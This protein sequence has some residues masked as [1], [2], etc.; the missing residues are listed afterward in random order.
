[1]WFITKMTY[2]MAKHLSLIGTIVLVGFGYCYFGP[3]T[4]MEM[5]LVSIQLDVAGTEQQLEDPGLSNAQKVNIIKSN[6][7]KAEIAAT[8]ET[9]L[10]IY[11]IITGVFALGGLILTKLGFWRLYSAKD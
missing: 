2:D 9:N 10:L 7:T 1:M 5:D 6:I 3:V 4:E 8:L 11:K